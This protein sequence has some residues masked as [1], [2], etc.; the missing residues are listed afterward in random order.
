MTAALQEAGFRVEKM[1]LEYRPTKLNPYESGGGLTGWTRLFCASFLDA[2]DNSEAVVS[3]M[4]S[5]LETSVAREDGTEW[6]G[7]VRLRGM[8]VKK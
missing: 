8:A 1:E 3:H 7:Y 5:L 6:L 4:C 2:V